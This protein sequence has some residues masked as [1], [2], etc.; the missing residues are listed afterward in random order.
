MKPEEQRLE[1]QLGHLKGQFESNSIKYHNLRDIQS[2]RNLGMVTGVLLFLIGIIFA[3]TWPIR[4]LLMILGIIIFFASLKLIKK[5]GPQELEEMS[6][7]V[8]QL[9]EQILLVKKAIIQQKR[10]GRK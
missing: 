2:F 5:V 3:P 8:N 7:Q 4:I 1:T 9:Q 6:Q 10:E